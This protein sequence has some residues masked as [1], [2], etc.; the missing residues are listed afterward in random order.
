MSYRTSREAL[1]PRGAPSLWRLV[2]HPMWRGSTQPR[3]AASSPTPTR[4]ST[5][6]VSRW[7]AWWRSR[8]AL[9]L[10]V[11][12]TVILSGIPERSFHHRSKSIENS[13]RFHNTQL[14]RTIEIHRVFARDSSGVRRLLARLEV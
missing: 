12:T 5:A 2:R 11:R 6:S 1:R 3:R 10:T 7:S 9:T 8:N 14:S 13:R 4:S